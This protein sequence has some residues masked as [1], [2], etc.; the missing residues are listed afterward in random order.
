MSES[1][2]GL[3]QFLASIP[4]RKLLLTLLCM[5]FFSVSF[6]VSKLTPDLYADLMKTF[7]LFFIG[8]NVVQKFIP[9]GSDPKGGAAQ[10]LGQ[11]KP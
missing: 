10:V 9:L 11:G 5:T 1:L 2:Q 7:M 8:G 6:W 3:G 4:N